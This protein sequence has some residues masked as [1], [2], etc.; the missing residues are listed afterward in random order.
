[1]DDVQKAGIPKQVFEVRPQWARWGT[2]KM[3]GWVR[4]GIVLSVIWILVGGFWGNN[5]AINDA[6]KLSS[7]QLD[8]CVSANKA[9]LRS[10][11]DN[12]EPYDQVWTPCWDQLSKNYLRN[13]DGHWWAA[14][15]VGLA[16]IPIAWLIVY[17]FVGLYRWIR[18]G[19]VRA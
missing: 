7:L 9:R 13:V 6:S 4:I 18:R 2:A 5:A 8:N 15:I 11:G 3:G 19:F 16:P 14:A 12:S 17:M 10:K 1:M